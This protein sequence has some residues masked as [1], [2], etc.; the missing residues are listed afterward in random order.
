MQLKKFN[1]IKKKKRII[2][3]KTVVPKTSVAPVRPVNMKEVNCLLY[4]YRSAKLSLSNESTNY[5]KGFDL[6]EALLLTMFGIQRR[7]SMNPV[8]H[9]GLETLKGPICNTASQALIMANAV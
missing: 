5:T 3:F 7:C 4:N 9:Y 2:F 6:N 1:L 8:G